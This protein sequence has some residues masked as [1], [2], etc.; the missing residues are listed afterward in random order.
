M[1]EYRNHNTRIIIINLQ[2]NLHI[3]AERLCI[4][5]EKKN[6]SRISISLTAIEGGS[7]ARVSDAGF[8][9]SVTDEQ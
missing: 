2:Q 4:G 7:V 9:R 6:I 3:L 8:L 1:D 5:A